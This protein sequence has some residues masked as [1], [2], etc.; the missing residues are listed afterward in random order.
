[1]MGSWKRY[2][3]KDLNRDILLSYGHGDG[4]GGPEPDMVEQAKRMSYGIP[5]CP[6][7]VMSTPLHY[8]EKLDKDVSSNPKLP[9]WWGEFIFLN[10]IEARIHRLQKLKRIC[11]TSEILMQD[12]EL[13]CVL[14]KS[15][16]QKEY[17]RQ[18]LKQAWHTLMLNQFHDILPGSSIKEVYEDSDVQFAEIKAVGHT[19]LNS[20]VEEIANQILLNENSLILFNGH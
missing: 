2:Q 7:V 10:I 11:E 12:A 6:K 14:S 15:T 13:F 16:V 18:P 5:G 4:G 20:A 17:P 8:F 1:M 19:A 9:V 3:Q